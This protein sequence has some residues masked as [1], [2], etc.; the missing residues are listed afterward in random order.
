MG[1]RDRTVSQHDNTERREIVDSW[2]VGAERLIQ[3]FR[4]RSSRALDT[5]RSFERLATSS[6]SNRSDRVAAYAQASFREIYGHLSCIALGCSGPTSCQEHRW[7]AEY[8]G[9]TGQAFGVVS[10]LTLALL[11]RKHTT[12]AQRKYQSIY[13]LE[14]GCDARSDQ[15]RRS[16][17]SSQN[18]QTAVLPATLRRSSRAAFSITEPKQCLNTKCTLWRDTPRTRHL[19][20]RPLSTVGSCATSALVRKPWNHTLIGAWPFVL[21]GQALLSGVC[22]L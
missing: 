20:Q 7:I 17:G 12:Y 16:V 6:D 15:W 3:H 18:L 1:N 14:M 19:V 9:V 21:P 8:G 2:V 4:K 22:K 10:W 13:L 5:T 11:S